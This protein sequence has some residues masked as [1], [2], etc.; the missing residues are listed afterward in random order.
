VASRTNGSSS[1]GHPQGW[2]TAQGV[3]Q[4]AEM[5]GSSTASVVAAIAAVAAAGLSAATLI[6]TGRRETRKWI[7]ETL[8]GALTQFLD[9]SFA[10]PGRFVYRTLRDPA[11]KGDPAEL[12]RVSEAARE[13]QKDALTKIRLLGSPEVVKAAEVLHGLEGD[14]EAVVFPDQPSDREPNWRDLRS[15]RKAARETLISEAR[16]VLDLDRGA[17]IGNRW[18]DVESV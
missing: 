6:V 4:T 8:L 18:D 1:S 15:R 13:S 3:P 5:S 7:R 14:I 16:G 10:R 9:A 11:W 2:R 12:R 17:P